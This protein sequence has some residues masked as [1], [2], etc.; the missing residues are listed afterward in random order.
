M[1]PFESNL[2]EI[3]QKSVITISKTPFRISLFGGGSDYPEH[4]S[5]YGGA[6][7]AGAINK[8]CYL[9]YRHLPQDF[10][11]RYRIRYTVTENQ[12]LISN[13]E[14]PAVREIFNYYRIDQPTEVNHSSDMPSK[15]GMGSSSS[16]IVGLVSSIEASRGKRLEKEELA[17]IAIEMEQNW[18]KEYV[19]Y[20]DS[21]TVAFGGVNLVKFLPNEAGFEVLSLSR[22]AIF[23]SQLARN[24]LLVR[25]PIERIASEIAKIQINDIDKH[26]EELI[27]LGQMAEEIYYSITNEILTIEELGET[28]DASWHI[29]KK[30][31]NLI[32]N[33]TI[34][35]FYAEAR[36]NGA[37]GGKLC[38]AGGG[39]FML[40]VVPEKLQ[41]KFREHFSKMS[42][43]T[44]AWDFDGNQI[45]QVF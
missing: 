43:V 15:S 20:Q 8:Y 24:L 1:E 18:I 13:I 2:D 32:S 17:K 45:V 33:P 23:L 37:L 29:K 25:I 21:I 41:S 6:V 12:S 35:S 5:R 36:K 38:G 10:G 44:F 42:I 30:Q 9:T 31:S 11:A 14:H 16:F 39:G 28:L 4:A 7:L 27:E 19:G 3:I 22:N 34:D 26:S 40:V